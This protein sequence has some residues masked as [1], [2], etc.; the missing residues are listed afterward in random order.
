MA[1]GVVKSVDAAGGTL[2]IMK[3]GRV[4]TA[5]LSDSESAARTAG[6]RVHFDLRRH[7]GGE[8][9]VDVTVLP[10]RRR[11]RHLVVRPEEAR[12]GGGERAE[13]Q[14]EERGGVQVSVRGDVDAADVAY[15]EDK[16]GRLAERIG[17]PVLYSAVKLT[18]GANPSLERPA[19]AEGE[20][21]VNGDLVRAHVAT[22]EMAA[23][24]DLLIERL[25]DSLAHR[26]ARVRN[27]ARTGP[28]TEPGEWRHG[29]LPTPRPPYFDRAAES[30]EIVRRK[31]FS[32]EE[33]TPDE[34]LFDMRM[35]DYEFNLFTDLGSGRDCLIRRDELGEVE[36]M[37]THP[38]EIWLGL[39][40]DS[41]RVVT[42]PAP[43]LTLAEAKEY[44]DE[45]GDSVVFYRDPTTDRGRAMYRRYDGHYGIIT[46]AVDHP[47]PGHGPAMPVPGTEAERK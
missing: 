14:T 41:V 23:A 38:D 21:D 17:E 11:R 18:M 1:D 40:S 35:A 45:S 46:P 19:L 4:F 29:S 32:A 39:A 25:E 33:L 37:S 24:V 36:L 27:L 31:T 34:A 12:F 6:A 44:L 22:Y 43:D 8:R 2:T 42:T 47:S 9:A 15:A 7:D 20:F 28:V 16:V 30:R 26:A 10:S 5:R 3:S 13:R